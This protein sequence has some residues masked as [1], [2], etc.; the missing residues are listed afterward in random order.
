MKSYIIILI[1]S[2]LVS[3]GIQKT[4]E[5]EFNTHQNLIINNIGL[6][7]YPVGK[8]KIDKVISDLGPNYKTK[9]NSSEGVYEIIYEELGI[10]FYRKIYDKS[11]IITGVRFY[12]PFNGIT[13]T[14]IVLNKST[15]KDVEKIYGKGIGVWNDSVLK[16]VF[17]GIIFISNLESKS[18]SKEEQMSN[19]V[20]EIYIT[21]YRGDIDT[22]IIEY[23]ND[24]IEI[25]F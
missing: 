10:S 25:G 1:S 3:C 21:L 6:E 11:E 4:K 14:G 17:N 13:D 7:K 2:I 20:E 23:K 12:A 24:E 22:K 19:K 8:T 15:M 5:N 18:L 9:I 16:G